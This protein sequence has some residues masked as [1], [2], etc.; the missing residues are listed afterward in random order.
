MKRSFTFINAASYLFWIL[1]VSSASS[2]NDQSSN[3]NEN[4][5]KINQD[6][7]VASNQIIENT[8]IGK[9]DGIEIIQYT[10]TN[11]NGMAVKV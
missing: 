11:K 2:C 3:N 5:N 4:N 9:K 7:V 6:T 8:I 1:F 10:L